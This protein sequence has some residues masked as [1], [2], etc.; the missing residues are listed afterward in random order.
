MLNHP[1]RMV[2]TVVW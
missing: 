2:A 1:Q